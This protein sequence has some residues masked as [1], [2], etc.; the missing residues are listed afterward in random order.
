VDQQLDWLIDTTSKLLPR[1]VAASIEENIN[2][3]EVS[4]I[5][6]LGLSDNGSIWESGAEPGTF[7]KSGTPDESLHNDSVYCY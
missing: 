6:S 5:L 7:E 2:K 1:N 3:C 4:P